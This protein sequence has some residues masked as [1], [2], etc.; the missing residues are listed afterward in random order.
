MN[1]VAVLNELSCVQQAHNSWDVTDLVV[2]LL[3]VVRDL[4]PVLMDSNPVAHS[5]IWTS[6]LAAGTTLYDWV[7][8]KRTDN[9]DIRLELLRLLT[10]AP[11]IK[12]MFGL[13]KLRCEVDGTEVSDSGV[14]GATI[15]KM[16]RNWE[17]MLLSFA[18]AP[19]YSTSPISVH[20]IN[21]EQEEHLDLDNLT[22]ASQV[23]SYRRVYE[24]SPKHIDHDNENSF[25]SPMDLNASD[26]QAVLDR[27]IRYGRK[28]IGKHDGRY[29]IFM[30][31]LGMSFHGYRAKS[32]EIPWE[33][34]RKF[35]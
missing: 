29:Y 26:A 25:V 9:K 34:R 2:Q 5:R 31:H 22:A 20:I 12:T 10:A 7:V 17:S 28:I 27:G 1:R 4:R 13:P 32:H 8:D 11:E 18:D 21:G 33:I 30:C 15:G 14:E 24:A 35:D 19:T 23:S 3:Q 6:S 16:E